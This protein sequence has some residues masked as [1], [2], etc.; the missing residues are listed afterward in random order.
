MITLGLGNKE[1]I[2]LLR[3]LRAMKPKSP[4]FKGLEEKI[5]V[6]LF[7]KLEELDKNED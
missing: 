7:E 4:V 2:K 3:K 6:K 1:A 5:E